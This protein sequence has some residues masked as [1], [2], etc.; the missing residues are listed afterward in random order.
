MKDKFIITHVSVKLKKVKSDY[1]LNL[2]YKDILQKIQD[3]NLKI[4]DLSI[5]DI[6]DII[7][8]IRKYKLPDRK[9]IWTAGSFFQNPIISKEKYWLLKEKYPELIWYDIDYSHTKLSAGQLIEICGFK[10][11]RDGD[12]G[13]YNNHALVLV[14]YGSA[15]WNNILTL[16]EKIQNK[17]SEVFNV[18]I[19]PEVNFI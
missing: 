6:A 14:N 5:K 3:L 2:N 8:D 4:E 7:I 12:A 9:Q 19:I 11:Y 17:V 10:W 16:S 13:V 15:T 18:K 1:N